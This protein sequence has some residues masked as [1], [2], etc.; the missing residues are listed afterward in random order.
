MIILVYVIASMCIVFVA[1]NIMDFL[2]WYWVS[3]K[4]VVLI[5]WNWLKGISK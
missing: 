4:K 2:S 5:I 3:G 1:F